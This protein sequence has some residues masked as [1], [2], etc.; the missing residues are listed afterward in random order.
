MLAPRD[1]RKKARLN[2]L[3]EN[4]FLRERSAAGGEVL[5]VLLFFRASLLTLM[6]RDDDVYTHTVKKPSFGYYICISFLCDL[7]VAL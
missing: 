2:K 7:E 1:M 5:F 3:P 6:P 4:V